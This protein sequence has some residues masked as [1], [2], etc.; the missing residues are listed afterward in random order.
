[1]DTLEARLAASGQQHLL[2]GWDE[3]P[4]QEQST[5]REQLEVI[6]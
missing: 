4:V 1:M 5:L 2:D 3:L 6:C